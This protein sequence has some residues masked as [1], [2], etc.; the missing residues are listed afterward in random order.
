MTSLEQLQQWLE[1]R[2]GAHLEFKE[3]KRHFDF[4]ELVKYCAALANEGGGKMV[5]GVTDQ[6]PR[7]VVGSN[8][9]QNLERTTQGLIERLHLRIETE[10]I[11]HPD[12]TPVIFHVPSRPTG[13]P[14]QY[15]GAYW[16]RAGESLAPMTPDLLKR[17]FAESG[18]DF[19]AERC[20]TAIMEDL[21]PSAIEDF[22]SRWIKKSGNEA[23]AKLNHEQ[24]LCDAEL[25]VDNQITFAALILFGSRAALGKHLA[26]SE[27]IVEYRSNEASVPYQQRVEYRQGFFS[28]YDDLWNLI[29]LRN[30]RQSYQDGLFRYDIPTFSEGTVREAILNA[31]GHRDYRLGGSIFIKQFPRHLE[32]IN[33]GGFPPGITSNNILDHQNP[34]NRRLAEVF[35]K[36]GLI[37]RSGQGMNRIFEESIR[38]SKP[39]PDFSQSDEHHVRLIL[40]GEVQNPAFIKFLEQIGAEQMAHFTT[41]DFLALDCIQREQPVPPG[42]RARLPRLAS[43]G[44]IESIGRGRGVRQ[45]LSRALYEHLGQK[46]AYTRQRGLDR[47]TN[48][49]L[50]CQHI[51]QYPQEGARFSELQQ[52]LPGLSRDGV[53]TLLRELKKSRRITSLGRGTGA[54]WFA[55]DGE[56]KNAMKTQ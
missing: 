15:K 28:F 43:L 52:V 9:F 24:L 13:M 30:D 19:S 26:Q 1:A 3:A 36:C 40:R 32:V 8:A 44:V 54:R 49:E 17:I 10:K 5:L 37:E 50:L 29:N 41:H 18:P 31:V 2:E 33:P 22:R 27:V 14:I 53:Q 7:R 56:T 55:V 4:E 47:E 45:I 11:N 20:S 12:G 38:Q 34:R 39:L 51:R 35:A 23:L 6:L 46:G 48:K 25:L 16:M 42:I 21:M